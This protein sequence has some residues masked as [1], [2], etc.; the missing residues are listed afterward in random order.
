MLIFFFALISTQIVSPPHSSGTSSCSIRLCFTRFTSAFSL[1]IL[2]I[3]TII[4][5]PAAFAWLI[6]SIVC[7]IIPSSAATTSIAT[8]VTC[9]PLARIVVNASWPGVSRNVMSRSLSLTLYAPIC[10]VIPPASVVVTLVSRI[11]SRSDVLPWS[12]CPITTTTGGRSTKSSGLSSSS[13]SIISLSSFDRTISFL[14][15]I[16]N[17]DAISSAVS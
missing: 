9:A 15:V 17:S 4:S 5:T 1:S 8:S 3:A 2:L 6:A 16:P 10:C 11:A 14:T 13:T 12:T 7:G